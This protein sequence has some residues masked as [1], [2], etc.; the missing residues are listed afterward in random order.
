MHDVSAGLM[1]TADVLRN[2]RSPLFRYFIAPQAHTKIYSH[3]HIRTHAA[4]VLRNLHVITSRGGLM[5][6]MCSGRKYQQAA[7]DK[8]QREKD[9]LVGPG[10]KSPRLSKVL[11]SV[12]VAADGPSTGNTPVPLCSTAANALPKVQSGSL[13][14]TTPEESMLLVA[15][16]LSAIIHDYDH[17]GLT[18]PFLIQDEDPLAVRRRGAG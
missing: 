8:A 16:Y 11:G 10:K 1:P 3:L 6:A 2:L 4:D 18:N 7:L 9:P 14:F 5:S 12:K 13:L 17:R 15:V